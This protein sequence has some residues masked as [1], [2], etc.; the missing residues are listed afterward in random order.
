MQLS[1]RYTAGVKYLAAVLALAPLLA[2]AGAVRGR[3]GAPDIA[4]M[5]NVT[6][7]LLS[8]GPVLEVRSVPV[9]PDGVFYFQDVN[10]GQFLLEGKIGE[11]R[12]FFH[13]VNVTADK[14]TDVGSFLQNSLTCEPPNCFAD[15]FGLRP[16]AMAPRVIDVCTALKDHSSLW[17]KKIIVVGSLEKSAAGLVLRGRCQKQ[18]ASEGYSWMN[19][20]G[21]PS[22]ETTDVADL[23]QTPDWNRIQNPDKQLSR[24]A[25]ASKDRHK[26]AGSRLVAVYGELSPEIGIEQVRCK[27]HNCTPDIQFPPADLIRIRG[28]RNIK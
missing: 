25:A 17:G 15:H 7:R 5:P 20:I 28:F 4:R 3:V 21:L 2:T 16:V 13:V 19:A 24:M 12:F 14:D 10:A 27:D 22:F 9:G 6:A 23:P 8:I 11:T 1:R 18:F 26:P